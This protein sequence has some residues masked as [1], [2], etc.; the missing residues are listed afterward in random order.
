MIHLAC[1]VGAATHAIAR[2]AVLMQARDMLSET[3]LPQTVKQVVR[4][5]GAFPQISGDFF[6]VHPF[7]ILCHKRQ[8]PENCPSRTKTAVF[9]E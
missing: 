8:H 9:W 4:R 3:L 7:W 5:M 1:L 6:D 2:E